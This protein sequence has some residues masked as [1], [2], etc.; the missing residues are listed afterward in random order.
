MK[1]KPQV[2]VVGLG[3]FGKSF[4]SKMY[5]LGHDV[6]AIDIDPEKV[7]SMV[8]QVTYPVTTDA[9]SEISLRELGVQDFDVGVVALADV[10]VSIMVSVLFKTL[11][12]NNIIARASSDLHKDTLIRLGCDRVVFAEDEMG[13]QL[14][15]TIFSPNVT[16]YLELTP[17]MGISKLSIPKRIVGMSLSEAGFINQPGN[18][19]LTII[20]IK[21]GDNI[22][23]YPSNQEILNE[24]DEISIIGNNSNINK[25]II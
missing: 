19:K 1:L 15:N 3:R 10:E 11:N 13:E 6:M 4:A 5:N 2:V 12:I 23:L 9:S 22:I 25:L 14:A 18:Q 8:G 16:E 7:Q 21:R 17:N 20:S 24:G